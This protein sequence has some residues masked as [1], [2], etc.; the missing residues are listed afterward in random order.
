LRARPQGTPVERPV[1]APSAT[2]TSPKSTPSQAVPGDDFGFT[3]KL[4]GGF[5]ADEFN[6]AKFLDDPPAE[7][8]SSGDATS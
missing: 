8:S 1:A 5:G 6:F 4:G 3:G 2:A 7:G